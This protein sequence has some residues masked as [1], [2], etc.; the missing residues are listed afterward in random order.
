MERSREARQEEINKAR[1]R[2]LNYQK[3][4]S[5]KPVESEA[6]LLGLFGSFSSGDEKGRNEAMKDQ[7]QVR[8]HVYKIKAAKMPNMDRSGLGQKPN[9]ERL[10]EELKPVVTT[11][12]PPKPREHSPY[13]EQVDHA[14]ETDEA[15]Q[16]QEAYMREFQQAWKEAMEMTKSGTFTAPKGKS[17]GG[18]SAP[19]KKRRATR[20]RE[21]SARDERNRVGRIRVWRRRRVVEGLGSRLV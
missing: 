9:A 11:P 8:I 1:G 5:I 14:A 6:D 12:L 19:R 15:R 17:G 16:L 18:V 4:D 3:M 2:W 20:T 10:L 21:R 7:I 13:P